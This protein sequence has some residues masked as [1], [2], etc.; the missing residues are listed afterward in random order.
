M[1]VYLVIQIGKIFLQLMRKSQV[2]IYT[3]TLKTKNTFLSDCLEVAFP[4]IGKFTI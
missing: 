2:V 1:L 3:E 4:I